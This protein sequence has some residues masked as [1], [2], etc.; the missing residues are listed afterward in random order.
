MLAKATVIPGTI[1]DLERICFNMKILTILVITFT[2]LLEKV[3]DWHFCHVILMQEF[4][5]V[6]F[7]AQMTQPVLTDNGTLTTNMAEGTVAASTA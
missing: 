4:A 3:A 6:S 2:K 1:A 7:L 5:V